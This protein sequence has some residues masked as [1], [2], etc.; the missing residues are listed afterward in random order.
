MQPLLQ[1]QSVRQTAPICS[2]QQPF[3]SSLPYCESFWL[4][5]LTLSHHLG[6]FG[7]LF[8]QIGGPEQ[9]FAVGVSQHSCTAHGTHS[10]PYLLF[11][12]G[13][14]SSINA[15]TSLLSQAWRFQKG[16]IHLK[17]GKAGSGGKS[18]SLFSGL[19]RVSVKK[20]SRDGVGLY[21]LIRTTV[22]SK[23]Y[24]LHG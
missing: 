23:A 17:R 8:H 15:W 9:N 12:T 22:S 21:F 13:R 19:E 3:I 2:H 10:G 4:V 24:R 20:Q 16:R 18:S 14:R 5:A 11:E 1:C 7:G 6:T